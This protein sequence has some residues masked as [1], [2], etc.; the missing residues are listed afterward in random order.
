[1]PALY[2]AS[3][4]A[5]RPTGPAAAETSAPNLT[6]P[7]IR[8]FMP[9]SFMMNIIRSVLLPPICGPQLMPET[10][11]GAGALQ[12]PELVLQVA[13]PLP[14]SPPT[15]KAPLIS[16]GIT[17]TQ[18]AP[19]RT[20]FG[21]PLS[22]EADVMFCTVSVARE[23]SE[24]ALLSSLSLSLACIKANAPKQEIRIVMKNLP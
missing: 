1:M 17:A 6:W 14:C 8:P 4:E 12:L 19:F 24:L 21:T 7:F 9:S 11:N 10:E 16:L 5:E 3:A 15:T 18:F 20:S 2:P 22:G 13:T 23:S